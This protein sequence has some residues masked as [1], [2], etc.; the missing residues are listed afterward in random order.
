MK[1]QLSDLNNYLFAALEDIVNPEIDDDSGKEKEPDIEKAKAIALL[2]K[3][4]IEI[5]KVKV[6]K[7]NLLLKN[8]Y[9]ISER[10]ELLTPLAEDIK[11][12]IHQL[13]ESSNND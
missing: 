8:G 9:G 10:G 1:N 6:A 7:V 13:P 4:I 5:E 3:Q 2:S 11:S 12:V